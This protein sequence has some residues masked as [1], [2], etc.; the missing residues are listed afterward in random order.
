MNWIEIN[1]YFL[2]I[3]QIVDEILLLEELLKEE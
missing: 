1:S 2:F 3:K